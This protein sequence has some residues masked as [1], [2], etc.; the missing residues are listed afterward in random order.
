MD[1]S[2]DEVRQDYRRVTM[3]FPI[4]PSEADFQFEGIENVRTDGRQLTLLAKHNAEAI[5]ERAHTLGAV[6]VDVVPISL[7]EIFLETVKGEE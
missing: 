6:S 3:G 5:V 4:H 7:R 1:V 2:L